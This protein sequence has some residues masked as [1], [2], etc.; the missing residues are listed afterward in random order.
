MVEHDRS[1]GLPDS[2]DERWSSSP[3]LRP[4]TRIG[5]FRVERLLSSGGTGQV[6]VA[7][8]L[9]LG[10]EVALKIVAPARRDESAV[11]RLRRE[12]EI[13]ASLRHPNIV[14]IY[15]AGEEQGLVYLAM[16]LIQGDRLDEV[17]P[18][19]SARAA[20]FGLAIASAL[21]AIHGLGIV[22]RDIKPA[23]V[24]LE[25]DTPIVI[26]FD[27]AHADTSE[28][29]RS[30]AVLGTLQYSA[31]EQLTGGTIDPRVDIYGLGATLYELV[32]GRPPFSAD[33]PSQL[34]KQVLT[35]EPS[36]LTGVERDLV[37]IIQRAMDKDPKRRFV[38]IGD[39]A[40]DLQRFLNGRPIRSRPI[41]VSRRMIRFARRRPA[42]SAFVVSLATAASVLAILAW[43][44]VAEQRDRW[45]RG[46]TRVRAAVID[47]QF[48]RAE[49]ALDELAVE[50][51]A[52]SAFEALRRHVDHFGYLELVLRD[53][54]PT[55]SV[56]P[57]VTLER[58]SREDARLAASPFLQF[59]LSLLEFEAQHGDAASRWLR[60]L[61][62][63]GRL[64]LATS[65]LRA[66]I[67]GENVDD[68]VESS[69]SSAISSS[70]AGR[71]GSDD[72]ALTSRVMASAG[73][74][75]SVREA[76]LMRA[77]DLDD[78]NPLALAQA[79]R[80]M[81]AKGDVLVS[82]EI[83][84]G[85]SSSMP[86]DGGALALR[87]YESARRMLQRQGNRGRES[88]SQ[89][90][91]WVSRMRLQAERA[92]RR[93]DAAS[94]LDGPQWSGLDETDVRLAELGLLFLDD[95]RQKFWSVVQ[96]MPVT[97]LH[98]PE[99]KRPEFWKLVA[100]MAER[101][102][103]WGKAAE[104]HELAFRYEASAE[105]RLDAEFDLLRVRSRTDLDAAA[106]EELARSTEV[107][108]T[109]LET[110]MPTASIPAWS[111]LVSIRERL[112][113]FDG[114]FRAA[115]HACEIGDHPDV[116]AA[117]GCQVARRAEAR[118]RA[119]DDPHPS[120]PPLVPCFVVAKTRLLRALQLGV[121]D[122]PA[123]L[124]GLL[125]IAAASFD[126]KTL[127]VLA[128]DRLRHP[129]VPTDLRVLCEHVLRFGIP[130]FELVLPPGSLTVSRC[131]LARR[132][133]DR[134][135]SNAIEVNKAG[136]LDERRLADIA[137]GWLEAPAFEPLRDQAALM[138]LD[139]REANAW[140]DLWARV[141]AVADQ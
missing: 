103:R 91:Y 78:K 70:T 72:L 34:M 117:Y 121:R 132:R 131:A 21:E 15:A 96:A 35:E 51:A 4:Q 9:S 139:E 63:Q 25:G 94:R 23:N 44:R 141:R 112:R 11:R 81:L 77:E 111:Q 86:R 33:T 108:A 105:R 14:P 130:S 129:N 101:E 17:A 32:S 29:T 137:K 88:K 27:L 52:D 84:R 140:E 116:L 73:S 24:L 118:V 95:E 135:L 13:T 53:L 87:S 100:E 58:M 126:I 85:L 89:R 56:H 65:A 30:T 7:E 74:S 26:D 12:S 136:K 102:G 97:E 1:T 90:D 36:S 124:G 122:Q 31:P 104:Y 119:L 133:L 113:D 2:G 76:M 22:H 41:S 115:E 18:V 69:I 16:K 50:F 110:R 62:E 71:A 107:V 68:V 79:S 49:S 39:M 59:A 61:E 57:R 83:D 28:L 120:G 3:R 123:A 6:Y 127:L 47:R 67:A 46:D 64:P 98:E 45:N 82:Y 5:D 93:F 54:A 40:A 37:V 19:S 134:A 109:K 75:P 42:S 10:R 106:L 92:R 125:W 99:S 138:L 48:V 60:L 43:T 114:A 55:A 20:R 128:P 80:L 8:Q 66:L 38:T